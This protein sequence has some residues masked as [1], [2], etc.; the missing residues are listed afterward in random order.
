MTAGMSGARY[1]VPLSALEDKPAWREAAR[2]FRLALRKISRSTDERTAIAAF[3][4]P[5]Y[6]FNDTAPVER[7]PQ[8][9]C[10]RG[11]AATLRGHQ[12]FHL[13]LGAAAE[14]GGD[15][16]S[17]HSRSLPGVRLVCRRR[18]GSWRMV[19]CA[20]RATTRPMRRYGASNWERWRSRQRSWPA[21]ASQP[22][23]WRLRAAIDAV[24][25][26]GLRPDPRRLRA[27]PGQLRPQSFSARAGV[28]PCGIRRR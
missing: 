8:R 15:D 11:R 28:L 5:G 10:Q 23:R 12:Q 24:V 16:Q 7:A 9:R 2:Y 18:P 1:A 26:L 25:A 13:R 6:L 17:V 3:T 22:E 27:H 20:C 4:S 19:P 21:I 14:G